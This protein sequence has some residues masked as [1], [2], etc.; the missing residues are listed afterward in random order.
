MGTPPALKR[1]GAV[2]AI[3]WLAS[4]PLPTRAQTPNSNI[5]ALTAQ[6]N[7]LFQQM[8]R[9]PAN[10]SVTFAYAD[11]SARLGDNEAAVSA[12]ERLL[13]FNPNLPRVDLELGVLYYRMGSFEAACSFLQKAAALNPPPDVQARVD[14]Y[15][16]KIATIDTPQRLTGYVLFGAQYQ[17]DMTVSPSSTL[18]QSAVANQLVS[19]QFT[20]QAGENILMTGGALY[21]YDLG[22]QNRDALE[23]GG[24]GFADHYF[25]NS[26][27]DLDF[28]ELTAGVRFRFPKLGVPP[29]VQ[30]ASLKPYAIVNEVGLGEQQYFY[31]LGAGLEAAAVLWGDLSARVAYEFRDKNF[32]AAAA[33]PASIGLTGNDKLL[34]VALKKPVTA[35]SVLI[36]EFD[37][38]D[39]STRFN[40]FSNQTYAVSGAYRISY[41]DPTGIFKLPLETEFF[42][43]RSWSLY[44]APDPC[45]ST[46]GSTTSPSGSSRFDRH[47]RFGITQYFP[48][49]RNILI[50]LQ[51]ERD[52]V[53]SNL[54]IYGYTS[55]TVL[56]GP[57]IR[58]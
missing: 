41:D 38:L 32:T 54:P 26:Q 48:I 7:L 25:K 21:S 47:W 55:N 18:V 17:S 5:S 45:C 36:G 57:Q 12:L 51:L 42:G 6:K 14:Q 16:A 13:L 19:T 20:R 4:V 52:V 27:F 11:I 22:T 24:V 2:L 28:G 49:A 8:L 3:L 37:F 44:A 30:W 10:L 35:N 39:Q 23:I 34:T 43:S 15:L 53:S 56:L 33:R 31:T 40:Y 9:E 58:F 1:I 46:N 29:G 50:V